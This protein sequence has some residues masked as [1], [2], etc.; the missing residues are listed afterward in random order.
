M[1]KDPMQKKVMPDVATNE[2][3]ELQGVLEWVGME[4]VALPVVLSHGAQ[5]L[6]E[7]DIFVNLA[8][9]DA[10]GIH[11]SRLYMAL[12]KGLEHQRLNLRAIKNLLQTFVE[13]QDELATSSRLVLRWMELH[14][15]KAL[16]SDNKGWKEYPVSLEA[17]IIDGQLSIQLNFSVFYSST[18]PCSAALSRQLY[19]QAFAKEFCDDNMTF[20]K[21]HEWLGKS[22]IAS[23]HSQRSR[24]DVS[25][26]MKE[27]DSDIEVIPFIDRVEDHLST[28]VQSAVKREDEQEFA[29][30][31]GENTMF[32]ED[33]LRIMKNA[34]ESFDS[35][36][37]F[38]VKTHHY[39]SLHAHDAV[40]SI[41]SD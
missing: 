32:V 12:Q 20:E 10:K 28:P 4:K 23:P 25:L 13:S 24:A 36:E 18:C 27:G 31:N 37:S 14:K 30:L 2:S 29:R 5:V 26:I 7:A 19:Q 38:R 16:L 41:T 15:R 1:L 17:E 9:K 8:K 35:V 39:E 21:V 11:M 40:G 34:L 33:A 22:Q 3:P 6:C